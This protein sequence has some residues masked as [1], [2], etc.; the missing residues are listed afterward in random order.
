MINSVNWN[1]SFLNTHTY[2]EGT[3]IAL[4][5]GV[6][7]YEVVKSM[8]EK[9]H[10]GPFSFFLGGVIDFSVPYNIGRNDVDGFF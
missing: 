1:L 6:D 4:I 8:N 2:L 3:G 7:Q 5:P 9:G 10:R